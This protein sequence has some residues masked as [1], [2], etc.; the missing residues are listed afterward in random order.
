MTWKDEY[1]ELIGESKLR[2]V[3]NLLVK[4]IGIGYIL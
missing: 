4:G 2:L 3:P 1:N